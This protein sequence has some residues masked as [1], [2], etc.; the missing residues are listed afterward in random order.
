MVRQKQFFELSAWNHEQ[1]ELKSGLGLL[2]F[3]PALTD[4]MVHRYA[5]TEMLALTSD[6]VQCPAA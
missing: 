4:S 2:G 5:G 6:L 3:A 1:G